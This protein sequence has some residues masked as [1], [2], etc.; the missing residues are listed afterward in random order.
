MEMWNY[1]V[2]LSN[3]CVELLEITR[4]WTG[5]SSLV[6]PFMSL[7]IF[8]TTQWSYY[9]FAYW[10]RS[11]RNS[12]L[13]MRCQGKS[14]GT[15][16]QITAFGLVVCW[17]WRRENHYREQQK[18]FGLCLFHQTSYIYWDNRFTE[19]FCVSKKMACK[20]WLEKRGCIGQDSPF[21]FHVGGALPSLH[22]PENGLSNNA[23]QL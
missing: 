2:R 21:T 4:L 10:P 19:N 6:T 15:D 1:H 3:V 14:R 22:T 11:H 5:Q 12:L 9:W 17:P 7:H 8:K 23:K 20:R 16:C 13:Q 18:E